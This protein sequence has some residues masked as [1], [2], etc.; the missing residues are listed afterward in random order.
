MLAA[1]MSMSLAACGKSGNDSQP[2]GQDAGVEADA[3][4]DAAA[5]SASEEAE[6]PEEETEDP[7]AAAQENMTSVTSLDAKTVME[8]DMVVSADGQEQ[9]VE[10]VTTMDMSCFYEPLRMRMEMT[11]DAGEAGSVSTTLYAETDES[12]T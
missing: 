10:S 1:V 3:D 4:A 12:G 5:E 11:V 7:F 6:A 9:S 2:T 8:M